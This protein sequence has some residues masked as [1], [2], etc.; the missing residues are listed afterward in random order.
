M[1][2]GANSGLVAYSR[3][4]GTSMGLA[5]D[6]DAA[7]GIES[8]LHIAFPRKDHLAADGACLALLDDDRGYGLESDP[9][10]KTCARQRPPQQGWLWQKLSGSLQRN[11]GL[12]VESHC[13]GLSA[14][15]A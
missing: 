10:I 8:N 11:N 6:H 12:I 1:G 3:Q 2:K 15:S 9:A 13:I 14:C 4:F 5:A 7:I